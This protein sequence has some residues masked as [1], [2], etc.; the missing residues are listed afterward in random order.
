VLFSG[1]QYYTGQS[2]DLTKITT[3]GHKVGAV[4]G[5]D[6]AHAVGNVVLNL[7]DCGADFAVWCGY[8]YLNS[9]P[10]GVSGMFV[11]ER[12]H[13]DTNLPRFAGWWGH[14]EGQRF[15]MEKG[16]LPMRGAA[17]WQVSTVQ[18]LPM[19][20]HRASL[21]V[22]AQTSMSA[23]REKSIL[24]TGYLEY[25]LKDNPEFKIITPANSDER[26]CQL[27]ILT[28]AGGKQV[29]NKLAANGVICDWREPNVIRLAPVPLYNGF[30]DCFKTAKLVVSCSI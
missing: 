15:K 23:L 25:L 6:L 26:G 20:V 2:F 17:G 27:S 7:H 12:H 21:R 5:F 28:G 19:A 30:V 14:D 4:V 18:V 11:H 13:N 29:F 8:K 9:G 3:A 24:L 10:G 16:F 22:F 1:V